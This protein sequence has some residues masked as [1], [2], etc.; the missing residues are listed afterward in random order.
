MARSSS[1]FQTR[2]RFGRSAHAA[3]C[4]AG[5][6]A[7]AEAAQAARGGAGVGRHPDAA[8]VRG[9][10]Q[11]TAC[12]RDAGTAQSACSGASA[13]FEPAQTATA[14][15]SGHDPADR[16]AVGQDAGRS[17]Q[18][19]GARRSRHLRF[20]RAHGSTVQ[21]RSWIRFANGARISS[22]SGSCPTQR[23][24]KK[25]LEPPS[26]RMARLAGDGES[27]VGFEFLVGDLVPKEKWDE[28]GLPAVH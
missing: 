4:D 2:L 25:S 18:P 20:R 22:R 27:V 9:G 6:D 23:R 13:H 5:P 3:G 1:R 26:P 15:H 24:R 11:A 19:A 28:L 7:V 14:R 12:S 21:S 17:A 10:D 8:T 16:N